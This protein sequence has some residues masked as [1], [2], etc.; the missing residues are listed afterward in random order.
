VAAA[1]RFV[2][3]DPIAAF[4]DEERE[5]VAVKAALYARALTLFEGALLLIEN[6]R[7]LDFRIQ[8]RGVIEATMYLIALDRN[9]AFV[10]R[11]KDDDYKSRQSRAGLHLKAKAFNGTAD[12]RK[13]LEEFV[14]QGLQGAKAMK[15][16]TLLQ[17]NEFDRLYR[18]YRDI[19]GDAAHVSLTS[20]N[21]HYVENATDQSATLLVHPA[22]DQLELHM[23]ATELGIAMTIA[24]LLLMKVKEKTDLW[25]EFEALLHRYQALARSAR[26]QLSGASS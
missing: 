19:S 20:L 9:P 17:G 22:L 10:A 7:Q 25:D 18:T 23:T 16:G 21:R 4:A 3:E 24:T 11:M 13:M 26:E 6:D 12:V 2:A 8:S 15:V 14:A 1:K 5:L